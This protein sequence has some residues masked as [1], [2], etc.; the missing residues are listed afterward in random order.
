MRRDWLGRLLAALIGI[1]VAGMVDTPAGSRE[2]APV[3]LFRAL[4]TLPDRTRVVSARESPPDSERTPPPARSVARDGSPACGEG[5]RRTADALPVASI[6]DFTCVAYEIRAQLATAP[7]RHRV[8]A[9][10]ALPPAV[11]PPP[12]LV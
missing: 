4:R 1:W 10:H 9:P 11:G 3:D 12:S 8:P 7:R 5:G 2:R 6:V